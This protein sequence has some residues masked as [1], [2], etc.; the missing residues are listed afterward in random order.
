MVSDLC[1]YCSLEGEFH[2]CFDTVGS[3]LPTV[4]WVFLLKRPSRKGQEQKGERRGVEASTKHAGTTATCFPHPG[5]RARG[6]SSPYLKKG[7]SAPTL[8]MWASMVAAGHMHGLR[9]RVYG[10][11]GSLEGCNYEPL[12]SFIITPVLWFFTTSEV[13]Q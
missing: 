9:I 3:N 13:S 12:L 8:M 4:F 7:V 6:A 2:P 1:L 10:E 11:K 5:M